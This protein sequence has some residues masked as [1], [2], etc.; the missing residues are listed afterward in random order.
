LGLN[1]LW[2][3]KLSQMELMALAARVGSDTAFFVS[4]ASFAVGRGRG[5]VLQKLRTPNAKIWHCLVKPPF[6]ISTKASYE[7]LGL[8][9]GQTLTPPKGDVNMLLHSIQKGDTKALGKLLT[10]SL[11]LTINKR[12][13]DILKVKKELADQGALGTLM[14][15][16]GSCVFGVFSSKKKADAAARFLRKKKCGQVF[17]AS[18]Y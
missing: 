11:E 4:G 17:V 1:W 12:V 6:G 7:G 10:N 16:S 18:T 2:K 9:K 14:S 13:T 3:L 8:K 15:G 5:E